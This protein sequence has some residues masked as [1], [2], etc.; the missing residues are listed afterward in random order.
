[1]MNLNDGVHSSKPSSMTFFE[2]I[3]RLHDR[4][5]EEKGAGRSAE[6]RSHGK[7]GR[8]V[9]DKLCVGMFGCAPGTRQ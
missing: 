3:R 5:L 2:E 7:V 6:E 9:D 8:R 4:P 1:M